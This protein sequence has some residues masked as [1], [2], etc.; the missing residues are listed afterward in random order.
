[1]KHWIA[2]PVVALL[3]ASPSFALNQERAVMLVE[4]PV[5]VARVAEIDT[6][7]RPLLTEL[8]TLLFDAQLPPAEFID[9][10]RYTPVLL[11]EETAPEQ[12]LV[13]FIRTRRDEGMTGDPLAREIR[14]QLRL[15]GVP[16]QR[17]A[18]LVSIPEA[19]ARDF[20]PQVVVDR[21]G[22]RVNHPH[23]G[24][25]GQ[26]KKERGLQTGAEVVH[27]QHPGNRSAAAR[28]GSTSRPADVRTDNRSTTPR[29][30]V[31]RPA[32]A[33]QRGSSGNNMRPDNS[34]PGQAKKA[35]PPG[36]GNNAKA[37]GPPAD[38][39]SAG[40]QNKGKGQG[41]GQ[42]QGKGKGPGKGGQR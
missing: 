36:R 38:R 41:Q 1:M 21:F 11:V 33:E 14:Q 30:G 32:R 2:A 8:L 35:T 20:F 16:I 28:S 18:E 15:W 10:V 23:G 40:G 25:P 4:M 31:D 34:P 13:T 9:I 26:L 3:L 42:G 22:E 19:T 27:G 6:V 5:A 12:N 39:G 7:P 37:G 29:K 17:Q 24:P